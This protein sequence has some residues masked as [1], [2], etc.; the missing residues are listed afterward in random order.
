MCLKREPETNLSLWRCC[1]HPVPVLQSSLWE[2]ITDPGRSPEPIQR[3]R[4]SPHQQAE[5]V[6]RLSQALS[7]PEAERCVRGDR[8]S[9]ARAVPPLTYFRSGIAAMGARS[10][11]GQTPCSTH[12]R[13][14]SHVVLPNSVLHI[15]ILISGRPVGTAGRILSRGVTCVR[16]SP[17]A[18]P[19]PPR[20]ARLDVD[21]TGVVVS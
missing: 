8:E 10:Q 12:D 4:T 17:E 16:S 13:V 6:W 3:I 19:A 7:P 5:I 9:H 11:A 1:P 20:A 21:P 15:G 14:A 18:Q 2:R